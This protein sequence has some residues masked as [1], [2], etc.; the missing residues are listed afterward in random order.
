MARI[1][2]Q[3]DVYRATQDLNNRTLAGLPRPLDRLI[4]LASTRDYNTGIYYHD[5]L[6]SRFTEEVACQALA[7]C[8]RRAFQDLL[9]CPLKDLVAQLVDY[10]NSTHTSLTEFISAWSKLEPYRIA[11]PVETEPLSAEFLFSNFKLALAILEKRLNTLPKREP[12]ASP[13]PSLVQ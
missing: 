1:V 8:H 5:G 2:Q 13:R 7:D 4:Y 3:M 11:I 9:S 6:A 12:A 10:Q